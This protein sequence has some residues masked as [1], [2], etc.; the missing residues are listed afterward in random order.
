MQAGSKFCTFIFFPKWSVCGWGEALKGTKGGVGVSPQVSRTWFLRHGV[1]G[2]V[3][4]REGSIMRRR[5]GDWRRKPRSRKG[6]RAPGGSMA[7]VAYQ[8]RHSVHT[9]GGGEPLTSA[10]LE[11]IRRQDQENMPHCIQS[12]LSLWNMGS[13]LSMG[14]GS[15]P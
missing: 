6:D 14:M 2:G 1:T 11:V 3:E 12:R 7:P 8:P 4:A 13:C 10:D 15:P 9:L 5:D